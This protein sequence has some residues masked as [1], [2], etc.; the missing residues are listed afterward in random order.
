MTPIKTLGLFGAAALALTACSTASQPTPTFRM[1]PTVVAESVERLELYARPDGLSL[2]ARDASAVADFLRAYAA[3]GNGPIYINRPA[4]HGGGL[5]VRDTDMLLTKTMRGV[6]LDP[7]VAQSGEYYARPGDPAPVVVSYAT[8]RTVPQD[9]ATL[10]SIADVRNNAPHA[11]F[12]CSQS[13][14][15]AAMIGDPRQLIAP[16]P[17]GSPNAQRRQVIY[18]KYIQGE[19]TGAQTPRGQRQSSQSTN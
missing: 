1:N 5:G 19:S 7:S 16:M 2:S 17:Q 10:G 14:N 11:A 4:G 8:L 6:G 3:T 9:C 18:D 15:L 13:A 12:G